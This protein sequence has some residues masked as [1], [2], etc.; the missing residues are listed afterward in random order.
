MILGRSRP[1]LPIYGYYLAEAMAIWGF[2][3]LLPTLAVLLLYREDRAAERFI[4]LCL[5]VAG[6]SYGFGGPVEIK[7]VAGIVYVFTGTIE[8]ACTKLGFA[9]ATPGAVGAKD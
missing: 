6:P 9:E 3:G 2:P 4:P 8:L 5:E 7:D 1:C